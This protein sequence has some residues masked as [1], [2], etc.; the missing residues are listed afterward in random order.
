MEVK[1]ESGGTFDAA[2]N[3]TKALGIIGT[4]LGGLATAGAGLL[5]GIMGNGGNP[6]CGNMKNIGP[7]GYSPFVTQKEMEY[8][9]K[10]DD[11]EALLSTEKAERYTDK[12]II[13]YNKDKF[14]FNKSIADAIV[15]DR[16]RISSLEQ[17][18][19]SM[20]E[21][22]ALKEQLFDQKLK[23]IQ[24]N[25]IAATALEAERRFSGD[26][27]IYNYVNGKFMPGKLYLPTESVTPQP[28]N[29][30]NSWTEPTA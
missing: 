8:S 23:T 14:E 7:A 16:E 21:I 18:N 17:R 6:A 28:M 13:D 10:I 19:E 22:M 4:T 26:Q 30:Y 15:Q 12:A 9:R 20:K 5:G 1:T 11:L 24:D 27:N 3:G 29:R 2:G 25:S